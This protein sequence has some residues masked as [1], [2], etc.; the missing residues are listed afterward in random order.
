MVLP[1]LEETLGL[2]RGSLAHEGHH[3][4]ELAVLWVPNQLAQGLG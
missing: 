3:A 4:P 1:C 2:S